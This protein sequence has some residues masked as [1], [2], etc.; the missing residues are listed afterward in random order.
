MN[1]PAMLDSIRSAPDTVSLVSYIPIPGY[2][3]LPVNAFVIKAKEPVLVDTGMASVRADFM[4]KLEAVINPNDLR[5][6]WLTHIDMDHIGNLEAVL[7]V[8]PNARIVSSFIGMAKLG[9]YG[10]PL[11]RVFLLNP[12][13]HINTGDRQL[14]AI[15]PPTYDAPETTALFDN[16]SSTFFSADCFG[17]ILEQPVNSAAD[18]SA[19]AIR[20]GSHL[21]SSIDAPWLRFVD[22]GKFGNTL[23]AIEKLNS[24][25]I[26]SSHLPPAENMSGTLLDILAGATQTPAFVGPDQQAL[27]KMMVA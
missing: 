23:S 9:L 25:T 26:L 12:G 18:I 1:E 22:P 14:L 24:N 7:E 8:A 3:V 19:R 20:D 13:Q 21:W 5:W 15:K 11:D 4:R 16:K 17:A 2:G 10:L 6:I 27:E